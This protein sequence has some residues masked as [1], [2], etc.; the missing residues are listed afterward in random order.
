MKDRED[1]AVDRTMA[2]LSWLS[3]DRPDA[4]VP[5]LCSELD[6]P[7]A[8]AYRI[9]QTLRAWEA[10][11]YNPKTKFLQLGPKLLE[12]ARAYRQNADLPRIARPYLTKLRDETGDTV[13]LNIVT[14]CERIC[15]EEVRS[16]HRLNWWTPPGTRGPLYAGATGKVLLAFMQPERLREI[17]QSIEMK[18]LTPTTPTSWEQVVGQLEQIRRDGYYICGGEIAQGVIGLAV[19]ILDK[20]GYTVAA[21]TLSVPLVR[22]Q[23]ESAQE[24]IPLIRKAARSI[25]EAYLG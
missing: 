13:S 18:P 1:S 7:R 4:T 9:L 24:Y 20:E 2:I 5:R 25:S 19:P 23:T 16:V 3:T 17:A 6:I 21:I 8:S 22:W 15:I 11:E 12:F 14:G 10:I